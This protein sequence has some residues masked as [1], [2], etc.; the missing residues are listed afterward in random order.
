MNISTKNAIEKRG[1]FITALYLSHLF[2]YIIV[3]KKVE[4]ANETLCQFSFLEHGTY[5][6]SSGKPERNVATV[7]LHGFQI[8]YPINFLLALRNFVVQYRQTHSTSFLVKKY[9]T[10]SCTMFYVIKSS[11]TIGLIR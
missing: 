7:K 11:P 1:N 8:F 2:C 3:N 9:F 10:I 5:G 4:K 6:S